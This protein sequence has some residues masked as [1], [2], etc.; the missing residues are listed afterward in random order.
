MQH[1]LSASQIKEVD[2]ATQHKLGLSTV[3]LVGMAAQAF[4][5]QLLQDYPDTT[6]FVVIAGVGNNGA[7]GLAI[8][9]L[10]HRYQLG[11]SCYMLHASSQPSEA[12]TELLPEVMQLLPVQMIDSEDSLPHY[13]S[14][15]VL[16]D[17]I[18]G[19]GLNRPIIGLGAQLIGHINHARQEGI[20]HT[21][22]SVDLPSGLQ[23]SASSF[24]HTAVRADATYSFQVP[25]LAFVIPENAQFLGEVKLLDIGLDAEALASQRSVYQQ[26]EAADM[27]AMVKV[28][29]KYAH[30]GNFGR[31]LLAG[32]SVGKI[33]AIRLAAEAALRVGAGVVTAY[34]PRCGLDVLQAS[35]PEAMVVC[36]ADKRFITSAPPVENYT[37]IGIGPGMGTD[38]QSAAALRAF[39]EKAVSP[40]VL[41]ADAINLLGL[42]PF[43]QA[44][45]PPGSILTPHAREFKRIAGPSSNDYE[46]LERL[47]STAKKLRSY[48]IFK[49]AHTCI[50]TPD[51]FAYFNNTGNPGMATA[52]SGD[53]LTGMIVGLL[54]QGYTPLQASQL[55][56]WL[57]GLAGDLAAAELGQEAMLA[58]DIIR[59]IGAAYAVLRGYGLYLSELGFVCTPSHI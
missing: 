32:G 23:L 21:V 46:A 53:T 24:G 54:A 39:L 37:A 16:I 17:A 30:K 9:K 51:G 8:A 4:V 10:L 55:G 12:T 14:G 25:K 15:C 50:A 42:Y 57:H 28:R 29:P 38:E 35:L 47:L 19:A 41:D 34:V 2:I 5:T 22:V 26:L 36:D 48:I 13:L 33:G 40:V 18:Y 49:G 3:G 58:G 31:A 52:G 59:K 45:V 44:L 56:V 1:F 7:D 43:M 27:R 11:V 20:L 6:Q